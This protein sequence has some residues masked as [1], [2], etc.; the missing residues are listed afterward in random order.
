MVCVPAGGGVTAESGDDPMAE[1]DAREPSVETAAS[2]PGDGLTRRRH[3]KWPW[4]LALL[5]VTV[6]LTAVLS[7]GFGRDP[8]VVASVLMDRPA[9]ALRGPTL[10]DGSFDLA[11]YRDQVV[12]VNFWASWCVACREEHP[13]LVSAARGL[14]RYGVQF[15]GVDTQDTVGAANAFMAE[16]GDEGTYPSVLDPDGRKAVEW[17]LFGVPETFVIDPSGR[18]RAKAVG[19]VTEEWLVGTVG[20]LLAEAAPG[21]D[22]GPTP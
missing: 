17:G 21:P 8:R 4:L 18:I 15:V 6:G 7:V 14:E 2:S 1:T 13:E 22:L 9:P 5:A 12:V 16:M 19:A 10:E 3:R 11:D 20:T